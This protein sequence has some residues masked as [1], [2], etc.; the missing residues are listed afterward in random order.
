MNKTLKT[1]ILIC[2]LYL[3]VCMIIS[4][5]ECMDAAKSAVGLCLDVVIPSLFP[6]F[7]CSSL[8]VALGLAAVSSR[9]LS[10]VMRPLFGVPGAGALAL[11]LGIVSGYPVGAKCAADL[12]RNGSVTKK[13]AERLTAFCN[14]SGPLFILGAVG[15][16][17][18]AN[19]QLGI[20]LYVSH[21][22][23]AFAVGLL[24]RFYTG[25]S[26]N[27]PLEL[28]P[29]PE[30]SGT[31][32]LGG[33][34]GDAVGNSVETIFKVCGFVIVFSVFAKSLPQFGGSGFV[35]ALMEITGGVKNVLVLNLGGT[36]KL[37][38]A[39]F[40]I[41]FSGISVLL[42]VASIITPYGLSLKPY[43][44]GKTLQ[45]VLSFAITYLM[46]RFLPI[47]VGAFSMPVTEP[48]VTSIGQLFKVSLMMAL[49]CGLSIVIMV[50]VAWLYDR[51]KK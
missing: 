10:P 47:S 34:I 26:D 12:Y 50:V 40:F 42:Q 24:F 41:A 31:K 14:N 45:G 3:A 1:I 13:E 18:L 15:V 44:I 6:F 29:A 23:S 32:T 51:F 46:I 4:P 48:F 35:Y 36:F 11:V 49:W 30:K 5:T 8:F 19:P 7:V 9:F 20:C 43:V 21:I 39:S 17:M 2:V 25:G 33:I 28:P 22:L 37:A 38:L 16:G 27:A